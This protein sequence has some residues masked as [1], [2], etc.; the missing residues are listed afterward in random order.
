M[1][2]YL[3][4]ASR[5]GHDLCLAETDW[6]GDAERRFRALL[7]AGHA[8]IDPQVYELTRTFEAGSP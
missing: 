1:I 7:D 6:T 8:T 3:Q 4:W 2:V 5:E